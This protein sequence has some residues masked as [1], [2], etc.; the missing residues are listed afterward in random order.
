MAIQFPVAPGTI[1]IC[2]YSTG[3]RPPEM[4]KRR[5]AVVVSPR[6]PYRDG[7]CAVVPLSETAPSHAVAY[8]C[9][10]ELTHDIPG[11]E[12]LVKWAKA[13]MVA[14]VALTR[15]DLPRT[16]RNR[17]TGQRKYLNMKLTAAQLQEVRNCMLHGL[18]L[19]SL[20]V[21]PE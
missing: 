4:V 3:F 10:I 19:G 8:Q 2:D 14:T 18:G 20:T 6:L 5:P 9:R 15:L 21:N 13:D 17:A 7:L 12:G 11:F 1:V 16:E